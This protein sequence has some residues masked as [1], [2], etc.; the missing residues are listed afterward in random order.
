MS[1]KPSQP[2]KAALAGTGPA[3]SQSTI[4]TEGGLLRCG[5]SFEQLDPRH[6]D[7]TCRR[8]VS[9]Q[10]CQTP[11]LA[12]NW[13]KHC[14]AI[15]ETGERCTCDNTHPLYISLGVDPP[16]LIFDKGGSS[17]LTFYNASL[18][19][20]EISRFFGPVWLSAVVAADTDCTKLKISGEFYTLVPGAELKLVIRPHLVRPP[21]CRRI[22]PVHG[23]KKILAISRQNSSVFWCA[24]L[25]LLT[26][27]LHHLFCFAQCI[28]SPRLWS[29][30]QFSVSTA[31]LFTAVCSLTP[32][33]L[34]RVAGKLNIANLPG[35]WI[36]TGI[37]LPHPTEL[38]FGPRCAVAALRLTVLLS[39]FT[40][41]AVVLSPFLYL[42]LWLV[43]LISAT[44]FNLCYS[45]LLSSL[46][47]GNYWS[48]W[49]EWVS[50]MF[51]F[52]CYLSL[53]GAQVLEWYTAVWGRKVSWNCRQS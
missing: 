9:C 23:V 22:I 20:I 51:V 35:E 38:C 3:K 33:I 43:L 46:V 49:G 27:L 30:F 32:E 50:A 7:V 47:A 25:L 8:F 6:K 2:Q 18:E 52:L 5:R 15:R 4:A 36:L 13:D 16:I 41:F 29:A 28:F 12:I 10:T 39:L 11:Y 40:G 34:R 19:R 21:A 24:N 26:V 53:C 37:Y 42:V 44:C 48:V 17:D 1:A 14:V 45:I 31:V